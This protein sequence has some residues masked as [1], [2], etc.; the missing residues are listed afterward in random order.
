MSTSL[1]RKKSAREYKINFQWVCVGNHYQS[2][3]KRCTKF[4]GLLLLP[5]LG[6]VATIN[7]VHVVIII[8]RLLY[9][10]QAMRQIHSYYSGPVK[11]KRK[12]FIFI[13]RKRHFERRQR[14]WRRRISHLSTAPKKKKNAI[15][16]WNLDVYGRIS[17]RVSTLNCPLVIDL[18]HIL[19]IVI[20]SLS[21]SSRSSLA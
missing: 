2:G 13:S 1:S 7:C 17:E 14:W 11:E 19:C 9:T 21:L 16:V 10:I 4:I 15:A 12:N 18:T 5:S 6:F 20:F 8:G 3:M